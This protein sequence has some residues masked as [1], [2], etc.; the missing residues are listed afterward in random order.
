V[1]ALGDSITSGGGYPAYILA[2]DTHQQEAGALM[3]S[4]DSDGDGQVGD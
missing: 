2:E 3:L 1:L 4:L